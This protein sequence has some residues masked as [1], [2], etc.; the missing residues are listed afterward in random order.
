M[1]Q[2]LRNRSTKVVCVVAHPLPITEVV[3]MEW[4]ECVNFGLSHVS[5][6]LLF[7]PNTIKNMMNCNIR[8]CKHLYLDR[9]QTYRE[10]IVNST[11]CRVLASNYMMNMC[12]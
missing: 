5:I 1:V 6:N 11:C 9:N 12:V 3:N 2:Q 7:I 8:L 10:M 4:T